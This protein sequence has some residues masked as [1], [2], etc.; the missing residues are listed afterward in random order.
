MRSVG[1]QRY[2]DPIVQR[3]SSIHQSLSALHH[4]DPTTIANPGAPPAPAAP[5]PALRRPSFPVAPHP[6]PTARIMR[7][8][9]STTNLTAAKDTAPSRHL[10]A[11]DA[12]DSSP[13]AR[14][15]SQRRVVVVAAEDSHA[16]RPPS[17]P[18]AAP[19]AKK[20]GKGRLFKSLDSL[21]AHR[22]VAATVAEH[23]HAPLSPPTRGRTPIRAPAPLPAGASTAAIAKSLGSLVAPPQ[24]NLPGSSRRSHVLAERA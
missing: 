15:P 16:A 7:P 22:T 17:T 6:D 4:V 19:P 12:A 3:A 11:L 5:K 13:A 18:A 1:G 20:P 23:R 21:T 10:N 8:T 9:R 24:G 2:R 14:S